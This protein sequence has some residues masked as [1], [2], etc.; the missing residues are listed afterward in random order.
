M[1]RLLTLFVF[2]VLFASPLSATPSLDPALHE[3]IGLVTTD[4]GRY[5]PGDTATARITLRSSNAPF[6]GTLVATLFRN[7]EEI[8]QGRRSV[9]I[10]AEA[11]VAEFPF[12]VPP[13]DLRGYRIDVTLVDA[14]GRSVDQAFGSVDV[15]SGALP[16][17]FPRQCWISRWGEDIDA[18]ALLDSQVAWRCN[19]VQA[20]ANYYR[21][22][23]APPPELASWPSLPNR[24]VSRAT[25][26]SVI[27]AAH[28]RGLPVLFFQ[29]TGEAYDDFLRRSTGPS[30]DQGSF[31][32]A[33][34]VARPCTE[35]DLD[36]SP[37]LP[38]NWT[39]Y[40]WQADHLDLFDLCSPGWQA[41][42]LSKSIK[43]MLDQF[44]FDGWQADTLG[45]PAGPRYDLTGQLRDPGACLSAFT[46]S[47]QDYL[48]KPVVVNTVS[49]WHLADVARDGSQPILYRETWNF[50]S[51]SFAALD[52][53]TTGI[54]RDTSRAIVQPAYLQR[55][56]ATNCARNT[57]QPGSCAVNLAS[58]LLATAL[59]AS[60]GSTLMNHMDDGCIATGV[61]IE[62]YHLPCPPP[63]T[64]AL[65]RYKNFEV[66]YQPMLRDGV[67]ASPLPCALA[68]GTS[69]ASAPA[70]GHIDLMSRA[71]PGFQICQ[72]VNLAGIA[73]DRW[74]DMDGTMP[75]PTPA[76]DLAMILHYSGAPVQPGTNRL[77]WASP[78]MNNGAATDLAY[79]TGSDAGGNFVRFTL[80]RLAYWAMIV[81][82]T[83]GL[84][85][86]DLHANP[87]E[88]L[89]GATFSTAANGI[90][91][92]DGI[93]IAACCGRWARFATLQFG[94]TTPR[95]VHI[96]Y[97]A[98]ATAQLTL[99]LDGPTGPV[100]AVCP[101]VAP[102]GEADC[103]VSG[104]QGLH[105]LHIA[106]DGADIHLQALQFAR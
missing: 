53:I 52:A 44:G 23:L 55:A 91:V 31:V 49:G 14:N 34:S 89:S 37:A 9:E 92:A 35:A 102:G 2:L 25:I 68:D 45:P 28:A 11:V 93:A 82:E 1:L 27:A 4:K 36:R 10:D 63:V 29:G 72:V 97:R 39:R 30:L 77:W 103:P 54:R 81:L 99:R 51:P 16:T 26:R 73:T 76:T 64:D 101:L 65:L 7:A 88:P 47:A 94:E 67:T 12:I 33:C 8:A 13:S 32:R 106:F 56:L 105:D 79:V 3:R 62:G 58:P 40:G 104:A 42:L 17:R 19:T 6:R 74:T 59:I 78:D 5:A 90:G 41:H 46:S 50:D 95:H 66:A 71:K 83:P 24:T 80:P 86:S 60:A 21:P 61:F 70:A 38:D 48:G 22:E 96:A 84:A 69:S 75:A 87:Y 18:A 43:P 20:Y 98:E 100:I 57:A 85:D 15:Q